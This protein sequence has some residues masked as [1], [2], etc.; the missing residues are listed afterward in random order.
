MCYWERSGRA[1]M[2]SNFQKESVIF[3]DYFI[4]NGHAV[5][6]TGVGCGY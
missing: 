5:H 4:V 3:V 6:V 2:L 1:M